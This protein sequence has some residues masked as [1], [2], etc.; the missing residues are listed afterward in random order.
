MLL[1]IDNWQGYETFFNKKEDML[2]E[3]IAICTDIPFETLMNFEEYA[4][5]NPFFSQVRRNGGRGLTI[6]TEAPS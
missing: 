1:H 5:D 4:K 3:K 6:T 2:Q